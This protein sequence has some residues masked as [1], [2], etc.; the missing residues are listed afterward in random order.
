MIRSIRRF[1]REEDGV[2][3]LE[4]GLLAAIVAGALILV[5]AP[6]VQEFFRKLFT[7]LSAAIDKAGSDASTPAQS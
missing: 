3:A 5:A 2:T 6:A 4:Y 7:T 1:M